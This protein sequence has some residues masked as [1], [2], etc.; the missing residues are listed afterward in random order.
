MFKNKE[1][2]NVP[3]NKETKPKEFSFN[4][5]KD[6]EKHIIGMEERSKERENK[7]REYFNGSDKEWESLLKVIEKKI[8]EKAEFEDIWISVEEQFKNLSYLSF[9][10]FCA[11]FILEEQKIYEKER[12]VPEDD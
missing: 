10:D 9:L 1:M 12:Y 2:S 7:F 8:E 5:K 3:N 6:G 4:S 11:G